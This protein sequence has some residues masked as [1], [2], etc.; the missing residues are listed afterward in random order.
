MMGNT[1]ANTLGIRDAVR[2]GLYGVSMLIGA[3]AGFVALLL[4]A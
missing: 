1:Y 3:C 2:V 4:V